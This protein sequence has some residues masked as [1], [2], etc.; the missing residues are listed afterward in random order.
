MQRTTGLRRIACPAGQA[1]SISTRKGTSKH[2]PPLNVFPPWKRIVSPGL[3]FW[4]FRRATV[5]QAEAELL[6]EALSLPEGLT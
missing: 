2:K 1:V 4:L 6:P 3:S 5:R